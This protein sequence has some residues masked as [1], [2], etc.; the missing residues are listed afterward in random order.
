MENKIVRHV[1]IGRFSQEMTAEIFE[2]FI[3]AFRGLSKKIGGI[4]SFEYGTNNSPEGLNQGM[5]HV[6][7]LTF[8]NAEARDA[9]LTHPDH[10]LFVNWLGGLGILETL[11][12]VDYTPQD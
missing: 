9:Y 12:V 4:L 2:E 11:M 8:I 3:H 10:A 1:L 6:I 5:T 7:T